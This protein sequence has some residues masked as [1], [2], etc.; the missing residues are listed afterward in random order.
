MASAW[1][2]ANEALAL[3]ERSG[4]AAAVTL[5]R[6]QMSALRPKLSYVTI[7]VSKETAPPG[8]EIALDGE[9]IPEGVWGTALPVDPGDHTVSAKAPDHGPWSTKATVTGPGER[10]NSLG[11]GAT[12]R[13]E[14]DDPGSRELS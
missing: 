5:A 4:D 13:R 14:D 10:A 11:A 8:L 7:A 12:G 3:A 6:D 2:K 9:K 1:A